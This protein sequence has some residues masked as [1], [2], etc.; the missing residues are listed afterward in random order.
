MVDD[1]TTIGAE[2]VVKLLFTDEVTKPSSTAIGLYDSETDAV[3]E[4]SDVG[5]ITSEPSDG[6]YA[7]LA[8]SFGTTDFTSL[9]NADGDWQAD[10]AEK[11]FDLVNTT[12]YVDSYF[13]V[14]EF[15]AEG[16]SSVNPHLFTFGPLLDS[17][18]EQMRLDL[19]SATSFDF[20]GS[21]IVP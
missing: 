8:Y 5:D 17:Q 7:Q 14:M 6:N 12:G 3:T 11:T 20:S 4:D 18:G 16:E 2:F 10:F 1:I 9:N 19:G 15:M 13:E 21:V